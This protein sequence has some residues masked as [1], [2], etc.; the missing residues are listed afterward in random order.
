MGGGELDKAEGRVKGLGTEPGK[1]IL[2]VRAYP[3]GDIIFVMC[4]K[5]VVF[6]LY[7][8]LEPTFGTG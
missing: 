1:P 5:F 3:P 6:F 7:F 2:S 8:V 4:I